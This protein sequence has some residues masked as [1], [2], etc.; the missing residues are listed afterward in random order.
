MA[1]GAMGPSLLKAAEGAQEELMLAPGPLEEASA[2][3]DD[4]EEAA[5]GV[6]T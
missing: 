4:P 6:S 1:R 5:P 3:D 2:D